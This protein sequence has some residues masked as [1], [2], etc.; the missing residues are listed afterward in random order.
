MA[1]LGCIKAKMG[2]T[3]YYISKISAGELID[4]VSIAK[5]LPE[6][7]NM[8]AE[9]KMQREC[10]IRRIVEEIVPYVIEDPDRFFSSLIVDVYSGFEAIRFE[11][12]EKVVKDLP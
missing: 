7:P 1:T 12:L 8:T 4:K 9:E 3:T 2:K 10:D 6:W 11:S 5:E